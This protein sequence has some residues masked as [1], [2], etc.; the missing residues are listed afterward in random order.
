MH[1]RL[2]LA[3][4]QYHRTRGDAARAIKPLQAALGHMPE[5]QDLARALITGYQESGQLPEAAIARD[6]YL[7]EL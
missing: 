7:K 6:R 1:A 3:L 5:R 2:V 4:A